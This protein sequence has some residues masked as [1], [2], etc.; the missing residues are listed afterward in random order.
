M[1]PPEEVSQVNAA[2]KGNQLIPSPTRK[3][4]SDSVTGGGLPYQR[5][6][7]RAAL[8]MEADVLQ[9]HARQKVRRRVDVLGRQVCRRADRAQAGP[10][11]LP[12]IRRRGRGRGPGEGG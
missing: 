6:I 11:R 10:L 8:M 7:Q 5:L 12:K 3:E 1:P 2:V 9:K 4:K